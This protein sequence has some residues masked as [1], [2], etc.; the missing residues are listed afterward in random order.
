MKS[1]EYVE[2]GQELIIF[3]QKKKTKE[4]KNLLNLKYSFGNPG[5]VQVSRCEIRQHCE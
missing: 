5:D 2:I 4:T 1:E 3:R